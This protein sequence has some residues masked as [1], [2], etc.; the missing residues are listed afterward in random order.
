M[1]CFPMSNLKVWSSSLVVLGMVWKVPTS[2]GDIRFK[3]MYGLE[4]S[5]YRSPYRIVS[6]KR[7]RKVH[8]NPYFR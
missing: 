2:V 3:I 7:Q 6:G 1:C 5:N 8:L 4:N